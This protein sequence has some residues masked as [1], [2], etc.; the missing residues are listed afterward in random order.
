MLRP[1]IGVVAM[2]LWVNVAAV[3]ADE[4]PARPVGYGIAA[5]AFLSSFIGGDSGPE[6]PLS[7]TAYSDTFQTGG[8]ARV[9][10]YRDFGAGWRAQI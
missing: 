3:R 10:G 2:C 4:V 5:G 1:G 6:T 9:E 7:D 8:G